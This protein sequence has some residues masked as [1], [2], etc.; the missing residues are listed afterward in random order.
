MFDISLPLAGQT[1]W[2]PGVALLGALIGFL[3]GLFGVGG[4]FLLTPALRIFFGV[5]YTVAVGSGL[6]QIFLVGGVAAYKHW[7]LRHVDM[8]LGLTM[9][10]G[11]LLGTELGKQIIFVLGRRSAQVVLFGH[12]HAVIDLTMG[13]L[14]LFL[15]VGVAV[16]MTWSGNAAPSGEQEV[17]TRIANRIHALRFGPVTSFPRS[18]IDALSLWPPLGMSLGVGVLTGLMGVGGGFVMFPLLVYALGVPT[19]VAVG[20][21]A[22][23]IVVAAG[24]GTLRHFQAGH[25]ELRL[26]ALLILGSAL[27]VNF[28]V[29]AARTFGGPRIRKYF[30]YV[31][32][33]AVVMILGDLLWSLYHGPRGARLP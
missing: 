21:S 31:L 2:A 27:S 15:L 29:A 26:V 22:F 23:Q 17:S 3:T 10:G 25:V 6:L 24:Y 20:T 16:S 28:G 5:P 11:A 8:K 30:V 4:G 14:F 9:A 1:V 32:A 33:A 13:V 18:G 12:A 19:V 7:R